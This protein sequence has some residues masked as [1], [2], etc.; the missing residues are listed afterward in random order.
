MPFSPY[1]PLSTFKYGD[2]KPQGSS[3]ALA[4]T[5]VLHRT[6]KDAVDAAVPTTRASGMSMAGFKEGLVQVVPKAGNPTPNIE[7]LQWSN[8]AGK[9]V[10]FATAKTATAPAANTPYSYECD[11]NGTVIWIQVSGTM[12]ANDIVDILVSGARLEAVR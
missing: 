5:F 9:F 11:V 12:A 10:S 4:P 8:A 2:D 6:V 7:V 3:A 1:T